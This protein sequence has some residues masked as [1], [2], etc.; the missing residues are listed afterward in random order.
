MRPIQLPPYH[1]PDKTRTILLAMQEQGLAHRFHCPYPS[2]PCTHQGLLQRRAED[3]MTFQA[4]F[5]HPFVDVE[6][7]PAPTSLQRCG[8]ASWRRHKREG[9]QPPPSSAS[10][11]AFPPPTYRA[12]EYRDTA[13]DFEEAGGFLAA[14]QAYAEAIAYFHAAADFTDSVE[15][16]AD[17][18]ASA[19]NLLEHAQR[20]KSRHL[21]ATAT[22]GPA[23]PGA[24]V[25]P[26]R[27][28]STT[29]ARASAGAPLSPTAGPPSRS[30]SA[31]AARASAGAPPSPTAGPPSRS[32]SSGASG[33]A[34]S[35]QT[36]QAPRRSSSL[37]DSVD[38]FMSKL[39][40]STTASSR[41]AGTETRKTALPLG[42]SA[43]CLQLGPPAAITDSLRLL[44]VGYTSPQKGTL[45]V[46]CFW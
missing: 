44:D 24:K 23:L 40:S 33:N 19:N 14:V 21:R 29:A 38:A 20:I 6:H 13:A 26:Q 45:A 7:A 22:A 37:F 36:A 43:Y 16:R 12:W 9:D 34:P 4:F 1:T 10:P 15:E 42:N 3:R 27:S 2:L 17:L 8:G 46:L 28:S 35:N 31:A 5:E 39:T 11:L 18:Q 30:Q 32:H 41:V 25:P